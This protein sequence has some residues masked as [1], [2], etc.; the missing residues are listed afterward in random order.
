M[1]DRQKVPD[2]FAPYATGRRA[3]GVRLPLPVASDG[4]IRLP[5]ILRETTNFIL[6]DPLIKMEGIFRVS[7]RA[8]TVEVLQEAFERAQKF[9][10]WREE[11]TVLTFPHFK[12][13]SGI[14]SIQE[15]EPLDGY[16][17]HTAAALIKLWYH[18]LRE[19]VVPPSSYRALEK[20][21]SGLEP[22]T[23]EQ[24]HQ[25]L[26]PGTEA[27]SPLPQTSRQILT[28]HLL[29]LL[30]RI[31]DYSDW[32]RMAPSNLATVFAPNLIC[33][34]DPVADLKMIGLIS[35]LLTAMITE[36]KQL[37]R[38]L[39]C[40]DEAFEELLRLPEAFVDRED[41]LQEF[42]PNS[43]IGPSPDQVNGITKQATGISLEDNDR[44]SDVSTDDDDF[45]EGIND[46][47]PLPP[48]RPSA[49]TSTEDLSGNPIRRKPAPAVVSLPRYSTVFGPQPT[50]AGSNPFHPQAVPQSPQDAD[51]ADLAMHG[52]D[53]DTSTTTHDLEHGHDREHEHLP[54]YESVAPSRTGHSTLGLDTSAGVSA[55]TVHGSFDTSDSP[56]TIHRKPVSGGEKDGEKGGEKRFA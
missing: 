24:L 27:F 22:H 30:S 38:L 44:G 3:F 33:G 34:P 17:A 15:L 49:N 53:H 2:I 9:I 10:V 36:W 25:M 5:R 13:G 4:Q 23:L 51:A 16:D 28:I 7:A 21:H 26:S 29:P 14:V 50:L 31:A 32:N 18:D 6:I 45:L 12:E 48:R 19:P 46:A 35:R 54:T 8:Q 55:G 37:A 40:A 11:S 1:M 52:V 56:Q 20:F 47:P 42:R 41:P 43:E 39:G